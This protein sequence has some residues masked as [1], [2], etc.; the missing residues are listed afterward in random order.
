[1]SLSL[2]DTP[3]ITPKLVLDPSRA[4]LTPGESIEIKV[5]AANSR[6]TF[7]WSIDGSG[8]GSLSAK[9]G[10][11]VYYTAN[12]LGKD[13]ITVTEKGSG[14][15]GTTSITIVKEDN[16]SIS[17]RHVEIEVGRKRTFSIRT[18][19]SNFTPCWDVPGELRFEQLPG[20][21]V[22][23]I[24][25]APG[26]YQIRILDPHTEESIAEASIV[27]TPASKEVTN[28]IN[29]DGTDYLLEVADVPIR[30]VVKHLP[31]GKVNPLPNGK[32]TIDVLNVDMSHTIL[33]C[34]RSLTSSVDANLAAILPYL[35][36]AHLEC[37]AE[38]MHMELSGVE[39]HENVARLQGDILRARDRARR[40]R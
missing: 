9:K 23:V 22:S 32:P 39:L 20:N 18:K 8:S 27:V 15:T 19:Q 25:D 3:L 7:N 37:Q 5:R 16:V 11:I 31:G 2:P 28:V 17:P 14:L 1:M 40:R 4:T 38:K 34:M 26:I 30:G 10:S 13:K 36:A 24:A 29:L 21:K 12:E 35:L 6:S 33:T